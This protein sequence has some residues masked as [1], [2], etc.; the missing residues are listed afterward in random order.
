MFGIDK[1][2]LLV[3]LPV[4]VGAS[5][6]EALLLSRRSAYGWRATGVSLLDL[7]LHQWLQVGRD[8][9]HARSRRALFGTLLM[10]PGWKADGPRR[11]HPD[12][13][14]RYPTSGWAQTSGP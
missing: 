1:F 13:R 10:A 12:L 9:A 11:D 7:V 2:L 4:V 14:R 5:L 6:V 8:L 3:A